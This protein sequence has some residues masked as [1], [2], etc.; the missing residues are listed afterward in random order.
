MNR[1]TKRFRADET[2]VY[3][4]KKCFIFFCLFFV[5]RP[6]AFSRVPI[7]ER[8]RFSSV[9]KSRC[10]RKRRSI[11]LRDNR[12]RHLNG[13][14]AGPHSRP[15][16]EF[17]IL[18]SKFL[19]FFFFVSIIEGTKKNFHHVAKWS[20]SS[21]NFHVWNSG[22][23]SSSSPSSSIRVTLVLDIISRRR[24]RSSTAVVYSSS[25]RAVFFSCP[26]PKFFSAAGRM[27]SLEAFNLNVAASWRDWRP[28][29]ADQW[30]ARVQRAEASGRITRPTRRRLRKR[31]QKTVPEARGGFSLSVSF[32]FSLSLSSCV[33]YC[34]CCCCCC[35]PVV[36]VSFS[37]SD[38]CNFG[39][40]QKGAG[41][42][43]GWRAPSPESSTTSH[44][45]LP[46]AGVYVRYI[47]SF[48]DRFQ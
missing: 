8:G 19:S 22:S 4:K 7:F 42:I 2:F 21:L 15:P 37:S 32:L 23:V 18:I 20:R 47:E 14:V 24:N 3:E 34:C 31:K 25:L 12:A 17:F 30:T 36:Y 35:S 11:Q 46:H 48:N 26:T 27:G 39:R 28:V 29:A 5:T 45:S 10:D 1:W 40:R 38:D 41:P 16:A 43:G 13:H 33:V 44:Q 9:I 6:F